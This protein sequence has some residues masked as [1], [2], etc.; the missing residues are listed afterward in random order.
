M[1]NTI[2]YGTTGG[3]Y[4]SVEFFKK[5]AD[6]S[7]ASLMSIQLTGHPTTSTAS[8]PSVGG[9]TT[10][11]ANSGTS[12]SAK[13]GHSSV[14][15][16]TTKSTFFNASYPPSKSTNYNT[17]PLQYRSSPALTNVASS[18]RAVTSRYQPPNVGGYR[19][20]TNPPLGNPGKFNYF[21]MIWQI[22]LFIR[23]PQVY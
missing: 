19:L 9:Y 21:E 3:G 5:T 20:P 4:T 22:D 2:R 11:T 10:T 8:K 7:I 6:K 13:P 23:T 14:P 12:Q 15:P 18:N 16:P 17:E 1:L